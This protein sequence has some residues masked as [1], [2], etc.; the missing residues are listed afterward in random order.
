MAHPSLEDPIEFLL[1]GWE[2][3]DS[4]DMPDNQIQEALSGFSLFTSKSI[5]KNC[6]S[7]AAKQPKQT[8]PLKSSSLFFFIMEKGW[9]G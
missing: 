1:P 5:C 6:I 7:S 9:K 3:E 4:G 8:T 2:Q